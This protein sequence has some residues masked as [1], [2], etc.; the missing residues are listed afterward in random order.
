[1]RRAVV[2]YDLLLAARYAD[3]CALHQ[4]GITDNI[5]C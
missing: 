2:T 5:R 3:R 1:M 4:V